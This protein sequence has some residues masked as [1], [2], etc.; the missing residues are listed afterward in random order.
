[1]SLNH[2]RTFSVRARAVLY[3]F[4]TPQ[5]YSDQ[6]ARRLCGRKLGEGTRRLSYLVDVVL[7]AERILSSD[8]LVELCELAKGH[9]QFQLSLP[10]HII[11]TESV[12]R[13]LDALGKCFET[14][15]EARYI[16]FYR[17]SS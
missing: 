7:A 3:I 16:C 4:L 1:M 15:R 12:F 10:P 11:G 2:Y 8:E 9:L 6:T 5:W 14:V 13:V 17:S